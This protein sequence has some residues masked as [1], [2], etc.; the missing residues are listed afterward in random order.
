MTFSLPS[1]LSLLKLPTN[2]RGKRTERRWP[3]EERERKE[4]GGGGGAGRG[5][6]KRV[7]GSGKEE[8]GKGEREWRARNKRGFY[9]SENEHGLSGVSFFYDR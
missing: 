6:E 7:C 4:E 9:K 1:P 3:E 5:R 8:E 2:S